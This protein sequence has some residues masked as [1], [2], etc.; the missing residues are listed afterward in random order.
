MHSTGGFYFNL[1]L[2][3]SFYWF[4]VY[5]VNKIVFW[6]QASYVAVVLEIS[7]Y[8]NYDWVEVHRDA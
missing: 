1:L 3:E 8:G 2:E 7:L 5:N 6:A 4:D